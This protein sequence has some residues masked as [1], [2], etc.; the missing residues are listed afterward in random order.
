M[1]P[2]FP[3]V[4]TILG[5]GGFAGVVGGMVYTSPT[6]ALVMAGVTVVVGGVIAHLF[7]KNRYAFHRGG[8]GSVGV[9][10][11]EQLSALPSPDRSRPSV[12]VDRDAA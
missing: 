9:C 2:P 1:K 7:M 10:P 12:H 3:W 11:A 5:G 8:D 6:A 4:R